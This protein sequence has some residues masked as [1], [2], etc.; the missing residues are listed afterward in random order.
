MICKLY[1]RS[2]EK[3]DKFDFTKLGSGQGGARNIAG[4]WFFTSPDFFE[5]R[6]WD[7]LGSYKYEA[8]VDMTGFYKVTRTRRILN[9]ANIIDFLKRYI[10]SFVDEEGNIAYVQTGYVKEKLSSLEGVLTLINYGAKQNNKTSREVMLELGYNGLIMDGGEVVVFNPESIQSVTL[11]NKEVNEG[12]LLEVNKRKET[13]AYHQDLARIFKQA[14]AKYEEDK[15]ISNAAKKDLEVKKTWSDV[16]QGE[17]DYLDNRFDEYNKKADATEKEIIKRLPEDAKDAFAKI[18]RW[19]RQLKRNKELDAEITNQRALDFIA[20]K[21]KK[22]PDPNSPGR[23][24]PVGSKIIVNSNG[25]V[26]TITDISKGEDGNTY[27]SVSNDGVHTY[28]YD[29]RKFQMKIKDKVISYMEDDNMKHEGW[30]P[31]AG[32]PYKLTIEQA[33]EIVDQHIKKYGRVGGGLLDDL[34]S[35]GFY[36]DADNKVKSKTNEFEGL[37]ESFSKTA[38]DLNTMNMLQLKIPEEVVKQKEEMAACKEFKDE[39]VDATPDSKLKDMKSMELADES[40]TGKQTVKAS[41]VVELKPG[42][43]GLRDMYKSNNKE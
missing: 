42:K 3:F 29:I 19:Y 30:D 24:R 35:A 4:I 21:K 8:E 5:D 16:Q 14:L 22:T 26:F 43:Q 17:L 11:L 13:Y 18:Y 20:S 6:F 1:H 36:L 9:R 38:Y 34:D 23:V 27:V 41:K 32:L 12:E 2:R 39:R 31:A 25:K 28:K 15:V 10:P 40:V 33:Q 37:K 7:Y